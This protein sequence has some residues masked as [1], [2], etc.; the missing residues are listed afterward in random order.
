MQRNHSV[1]TVLINPFNGSLFVVQDPNQFF[2]DSWQPDTE[3]G[4]AASPWYQPGGGGYVAPTAPPSSGATETMPIISNGSTTKDTAPAGYTTVYFRDGSSQQ[5]PTVDVEYWRSYWR[6]QGWSSSPVVQPGTSGPMDYSAIP[7]DVLG[8]PGWS[9]LTTDQK[10]IVLLMYK[11][12]TASDAAAKADAIKNLEEAT[13]LADPYFKSQIRL[14]QDEL[15]RSFGSTIGDYQSQAEK[16]RRRS[17]EIRQDLTFNREN[18][19]LEERS[20]LARQLREYNSTLETLTTNMQES[21]LAF[22]SPRAVAEQ[23]LKTEQ[24]EV[25]QSTTRQYAKSK[26]DL[27]LAAGRGI[28]DIEQAKTD[29]ER[30]K[31]EALT[32]AAR[33]AEERLGTGNLPGSAAGQPIPQLGTNLTGTLEAQRQQSIL[34]LEEAL[35]NRQAPLQF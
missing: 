35:R 29:L 32:A 24:Q 11:G 18:L 5:V 13:K 17:E 9:Q 14:V 15:E 31:Q 12:L 2:S 19:S 3:A 23:R 28:Q 8:S 4:R 16:L 26:R 25:A 10:N 33:S 6:S 30:Q 20:E 34:Q 21:G 27:E 1:G 22:S 7:S